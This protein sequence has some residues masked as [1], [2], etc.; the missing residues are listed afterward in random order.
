M[1][2]DYMI[3]FQY[4]VRM[5]LTADRDKSGKATDYGKCGYIDLIFSDPD[6]QYHM[7][8]MA[9]I[10]R[11]QHLLRIVVPNETPWDLE[12]RGTTRLAALR[13]EIVVLGTKNHP[14]RHTLVLRGGNLKDLNLSEISVKDQKELRD[15]K[16]LEFWESTNGEA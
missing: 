16:L 9:A 3:Q 12:L 6:S 7:S 8:L 1:L 15:L 11:K 2:R 5:D 14:L 13:D 10:W 4:V